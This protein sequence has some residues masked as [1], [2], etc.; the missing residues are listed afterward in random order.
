MNLLQESSSEKYSC[1]SDS[2]DTINDT[3][4]NQ[5]NTINEIER[6]SSNIIN[7]TYLQ[8]CDINK[9]LQIM[10]DSYDMEMCDMFSLKRAYG[11][12]ISKY[13]HI[14]QEID[15]VEIFDSNIGDTVKLLNFPLINLSVNEI[16]YKIITM[17]DIIDKYDKLEELRMDKLTNK[18][19]YKIVH[20]L[21]MPNTFKAK[22][23][24]QV[25]QLNN[26]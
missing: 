21:G 4:S 19:D 26:Y 7:D 10:I 9:N 8:L 25:I 13:E 20:R 1:D 23:S 15:Q 18:T 11:N 12:L 22:R 14:Y 6:H 5:N 2:F 17:N 3:Y 24:N 16:A